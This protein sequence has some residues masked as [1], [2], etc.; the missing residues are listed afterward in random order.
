MVGGFSF[1]ISQG[2]GQHVRAEEHIGIGKQQPVAGRLIGC[3]PHGVHLPQPTRRQ[4]GDVNHFQPAAGFG[5]GR[6]SIHDFAGAV[7]GA[8]VDR[9]DF[10][11]VVIEGQQRRKGWPDVFFLV[12]SRNDDADA[13]IPV[14]GGRLPVPLGPRDV[15][16]LGHAQGGIHQARKPNQPEDA[17]GNPMEN[18]PV[19]IT[20]PGWP[21]SGPRL[22]VDTR[23]EERIAC[24]KTVWQKKPPWR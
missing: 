3:A 6:D 19:K 14:R 10:V 23:R 5:S 8:I 7:G 18:V 9:D 11:V 16:D 17:A 13:R 20:H 24:R 15:G 12:A 2:S 4:F 21:L 1:G 22:V